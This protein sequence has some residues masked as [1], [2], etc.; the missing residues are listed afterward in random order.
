LELW[1]RFFKTKTNLF[2]GEK[3][4]MNDAKKLFMAENM[5]DYQGHKDIEKALSTLFDLGLSEEIRAM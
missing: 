1:A 2:I 3:I 4:S 5:V